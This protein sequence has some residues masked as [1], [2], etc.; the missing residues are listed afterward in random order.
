[1]CPVTSLN[2]E[3][4]VRQREAFLAGTPGP[5]FPG[6]EGEARH[7]DRPGKDLLKSWTGDEGVTA[8]GLGRLPVNEGDQP[9]VKDVVEKAN[10]I[11]GF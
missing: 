7:V 3:Y 5:D 1:M 9:G 2:A 4:L 11:L 10:K 6:G 8:M